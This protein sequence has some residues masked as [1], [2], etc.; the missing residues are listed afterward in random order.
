MVL[1][2]QSLWSA[3][4][5]TPLFLTLVAPSQFERVQ[6]PVRLEQSEQVPA[7]QQAAIRSPSEVARFLVEHGSVVDVPGEGKVTRQINKDAPSFATPI[8]P[9]TVLLLRL[10]QY[11]APY[12]LTITS[13]R[14]GMGLTT[15]V[16]IPSGI[17]FD[18][19]FRPVK[20]FGEERLEGRVDSLAFELLFGEATRAAQ[21]V[22]LYTRGDL[23]RQR[24]GLRDYRTGRRID[25]KLD[26]WLNKIERSLEGK[27][28]V[29]TRPPATSDVAK[30][31]GGAW[32]QLEGATEAHVQQLV[33]SPSLVQS[34][35]A[36]TTWY[37][38]GTRVGTV[39]VYI[40]DGV[41]S[42]KPRK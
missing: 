15:E 1:V 39:K 26:L 40:I 18:A 37:Y 12:V 7:D 36:V 30:K 34:Q 6:T 41:A 38:D 25:G 16:F 20:E 28:E 31:L 3:A 23:V 32:L 14:K 24:L 19:E 9:T 13:V 2:L 35:G 33:G 10:P 5:A 27:I 17:S 8:G 22:L 11:Q 4:M 42:L 29:Q 21:Y